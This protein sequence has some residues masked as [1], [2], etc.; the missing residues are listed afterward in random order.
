MEFFK[1]IPH[2]DFMRV[3]KIAVAAS[4]VVLLIA[5]GSLAYQGL[6]LA[7][8]F[9]GGT[10]V[11]VHYPQAT[12]LGAVRNALH[13]GGFADA[14]VQHFGTP[15]EVLIHL[16]AQND[17]KNNSIGARVT[18]LLQ[19]A[20]PGAQVRRVDTVGAEVGS[21]LAQKGGIAITVTLVLIL[22]YLAFRFEWRLAL[23][24]VAATLHDIVFVIGFFS[25]FRFQ[26]DLNVLAA[27]LAVMG[28]SV[29]DTVVVFDRIREDFR[30]LRRASAYEIVNAAV[31]QTLS[32][33]I[34]TS[35]LTLLV[36]IAMLAVGG[37]VLFGFSLCLLVGIV[38]GTY[39]S[40]YIA[41]GVALMLGV[42]RQDLMI[43]KK[44]DLVD[45]RP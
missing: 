29:N 2:I 45:D 44:E 41:S 21:D 6:N 16:Q 5:I 8:D 19:K 37:P 43:K 13:S 4:I 34:M 30:K 35:G 25:I 24:A 12:D 38:V 15:E 32:R 31:N 20:N 17:G 1:N 3:R 26:F 28:Y 23:G 18:E 11:E 40:I 42:S 22:F 36:V 33:T 39:S 27:V 9:T 7:I 14:S 10:V